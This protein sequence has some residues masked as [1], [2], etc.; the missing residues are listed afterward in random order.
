MGTVGR[1]RDALCLEILA[2]TVVDDVRVSKAFGN[3]VWPFHVPLHWHN[4]TEVAADP[5]KA[6]IIC[7]SVRTD[8][9]GSSIG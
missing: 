5:Q 6:S 2:D 8:D 7:P 4:L 9:L 1:D 3:L